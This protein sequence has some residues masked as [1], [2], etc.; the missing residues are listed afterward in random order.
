[1]SSFLASYSEETE[2]FFELRRITM[3]IFWMRYMVG[4]KYIRWGKGRVL[5][6]QVLLFIFSTILRGMYYYYLPATV[7]E[8]EAQRE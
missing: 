2:T 1:M 6:S 8:I 4:V 5:R 7:K 3:L